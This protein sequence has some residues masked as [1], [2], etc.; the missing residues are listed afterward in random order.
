MVQATCM[1]D[2]HIGDFDFLCSNEECRYDPNGMRSVLCEYC[3]FKDYSDKTLLH[4]YTCHTIFE[5]EQKKEESSED[6]S[7]GWKELTRQNYGRVQPP[8]ALQL[9]ASYFRSNPQFFTLPD[10]F[11]P[12]F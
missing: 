8:Q 11:D 12:T 1:P 6:D 4:C 3:C 7:D 5:A 2:N 10:I 9:L